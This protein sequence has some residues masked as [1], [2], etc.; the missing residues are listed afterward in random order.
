MSRQDRLTIA[1]RATC[2]AVGTSA[3]ALVTATA[4]ATAAFF[5]WAAAACRLAAEAATTAIASTV[6]RRTWWAAAVVAWTPAAWL[7]CCACR[8]SCL[9]RLVAFNDINRNRLLGEALDTFDVH[10][11]SMIDQRHGNAVAAGTTGTADTVN[12]I[13]REFRQI[14][15][16]HVGDARH[17]DT[18]SGDVGSDQHANLA[19]THAVQS[20]V[21]CA[22]M[23]VAMQSSS[24]ETSDVQTISDGVGVTLGRSEDNSLIHGHVAQQEVQQAI[25]VRQIVD[26]VHALSDVFMLG[27]GTG[28]LDDLRCIGDA[29]CHV[30]ENSMVWRVAGVAATIFSMSS[31]KPMSSMRSASSSTRISSSEKSI[32]PESIWS[33]RRPGVATRISGLRD[34]N[35]ICFG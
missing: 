4:T 33:I 32:L 29:L 19:A 18:A 21:T 12:V 13:F 31:M 2:A 26:E 8:C 30:A 6:T 9:L 7:A 27:G 1:V 14:V 3:T 35:C 23:H 15:V 10:A 16:E 5:T 22:L 25:L 20:A 28:D 24:S 34:S 17:V 11:F